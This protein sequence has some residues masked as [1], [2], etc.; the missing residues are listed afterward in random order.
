MS[1]IERIQSFLRENARRLYNS[2]ATPPFTLFFH[3][4][5]GFKY[6]NYAIP[7]EPVEGDLREPLERLRSEFR[8][9]GRLPRFEFIEAF[10]PQLPAILRQQGFVE[11]ARQWSMLCSHQAYRTSPVVPDLQILTL[12]PDSPDTDVCDFLTTQRAGFGDENQAQPTPQEI[13]ST[14]DS[15]KRGWTAF[16]GRLDGQPAGVAGYSNIIDGV[17]EVGGVA[18]LVAYRR[19][20][21]ASFLTARA[22][23]AAFERGA[24]TICL[25]A[26]DERAG[27]VYERIGFKPFSIMLAYSDPDESQP[28][29]TQ[30]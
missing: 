2:V 19:R 18:T 23:E 15:F 29:G 5:E 9:R 11:E 6:F 25:T 14:R 20:G 1:D 16:L 26:E 22:V 30:L 7:D 17:C 4:D 12:S 24:D 13:Q 10:A 3:P 28:A 8:R 21:I 27:R